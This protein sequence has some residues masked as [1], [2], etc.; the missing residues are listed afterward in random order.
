MCDPFHMLILMHNLGRGYTVWDTSATIR[1]VRPGRGMVHATFHIPLATIDEIRSRAD[2]GEKVEPEF[3]VDVVDDSGQI[4]A[5]VDKR[6][7]VRKKEEA[8]A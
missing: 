3:H 4:V 1:F 5:Q 7:Y 2:Q 6:L 8:P